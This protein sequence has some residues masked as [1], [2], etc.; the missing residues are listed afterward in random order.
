MLTSNGYFSL[1]NIPTRVT[2]NSATIIDH[3]MTN[4]HQ[5]HIIPWVIKSDLSDHYPTFC[6]VSNL[7]NKTVSKHKA[8]YQCNFTKFKSEKFCESLHNAVS[9]FFS[10]KFAINSENF[11][12][13]FSEFVKIITNAINEHAP[14]KKLSR[15]QQRLKM[16]P[17]ITHGILK[18][19]KRKQKLYS[20][21][22]VKGNEIQKQF[23]KKYSNV[24]TKLKF[25]AKKLFYHNKFESSKNDAYK[26]WNT[27]K[28]L[29]STRKV[30]SP[31]PNKLKL[32]NTFTANHATMAEEF[33]KYFSEIGK[34]L[35]DKINNVNKNDYINYLPERLSSSLFLNPTTPNEVFKVICSLKDTKSCGYD[36]ISSFFLRIS[37]NVLATPLSYLYNCSFQLGIFP[38]SLKIAK[39]LPIYK[40][41][42]K[43]EIGNYRPI[44]ILSTISKLLEKLIFSRTTAFFEKHSVIL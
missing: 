2:E 23:Y 16:K 20:T 19:I 32:K 41:G 25:A 8:I 10:N 24:L 31:T 5:H 7:V 14:L 27:I 3:I 30:E 9:S 22:Y 28:S 39:V 4:D 43:S 38:D 40:S 13:V 12:Y 11:N 6:I 35:A 34:S 26:T 15:A 29:I 37:A 44:S 17:W 33:N 21:H 36:N 18:S 1:V 42:E